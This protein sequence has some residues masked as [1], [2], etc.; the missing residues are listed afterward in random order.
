MRHEYDYLVPCP[1]CK[2]TEVKAFGYC[3]YDTVDIVCQKCD[4]VTTVGVKE[5]YEE[6]NNFKHTGKMSVGFVGNRE[7]PEMR[8]DI[9][10]SK[11]EKIQ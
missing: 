1:N 4:Y 5:F 8:F 10:M 7:V 3:C 11:K 6:E 2:S 9:D